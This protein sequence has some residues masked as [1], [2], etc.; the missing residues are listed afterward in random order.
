MSPHNPL[1]L[2]EYADINGSIVGTFINSSSFLLPDTATQNPVNPTAGPTPPV[3][4]SFW[5]ANS[6]NIPSAPI[7]YANGYDNI[8]KVSDAKQWNFTHITSN[9]NPVLAMPMRNVI[10]LRGGTDWRMEIPLA[11]GGGQY[12]N[13]QLSFRDNAGTRG[14][15]AGTIPVIDFSNAVAPFS[16]NV[17][18]NVVLRT[19]GHVFMALRAIDNSITPVWSMFAM[20][21]IIVP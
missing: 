21:W 14:D 19:T 10:F 9:P 8:Q 3:I 17:T 15:Y 16:G 13:L 7:C 2:I 6:F 18:L 11:L 5:S 4:A 12:P 1:D 20:E